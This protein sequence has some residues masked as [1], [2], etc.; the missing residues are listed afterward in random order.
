[1]RFRRS[2]L[3]FFSAVL[4]MPAP[5]F[6]AAVRNPV[7][8]ALNALAANDDGSTG[9]V[10]LGFTVNFFGAGG[11]SVFVNNNGNVTFTQALS[12]FT[13]NGLA[14]GVGQ[15]IIAPF[16]AD[17]DTR[18][19]GSGLTTWGNAT[20]NG[21]SAFVVNWP[22]VGYF[23]GHTDKL[24]NFQLILTD[25]TDTGAGNFDIEFNYNT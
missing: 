21:F 15:P 4:T 25:R 2:A 20:Y 13:P 3:V 19:A 1:M 7:G 18:G 23:N 12:Q 10:P 24:A 8:S 17:V 22:N 6:S 14:T 16:F 5:A 11:G 9:A